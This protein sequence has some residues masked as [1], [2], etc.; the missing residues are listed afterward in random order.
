VSKEFRDFI[1]AILKKNPKERLPCKDLL[2][3]EFIRKYRDL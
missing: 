1:V 3:M 2:A